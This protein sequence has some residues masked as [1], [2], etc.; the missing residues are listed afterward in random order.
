VADPAS[1]PSGDCADP[2]QEFGN[3]PDLN[4]TRDAILLDVD[5]TLV[6]IAPRPD[7]VQVPRSLCATL[8]RLEDMSG[9]AV[10]LISGRPLKSLDALFGGLCLPASGSH[11]AEIRPRADG[12]VIAAPRLPDGMQE[13]FAALG[14]DFPGLLVED[15]G[16]TLAFHY[17]E[18]EDREP[19]ILAAVDARMSEV[20]PEYELLRGKAI[21]EVKPRGFDKGRALRQLM[22]CPP[23]SGRRPVFPGD[24]ITDEDVFAAL[25]AYGGIGI[26]VGRRMRGAKYC[27]QSP[28]DIRGWLARL[29]G[30]APGSEP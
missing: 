24:D 12:P 11:G 29:A 4:L 25:P 19:Q 16:Y 28:R 20:P 3:L 6:D 13:L 1:I 21:V 2:A 7:L 26:S 5:G 18:I 23:F 9:G 10:A 22:A 27:V 17:R 14:R 8:A 15:K 30:M